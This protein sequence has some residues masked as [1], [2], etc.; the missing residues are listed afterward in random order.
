[1]EEKEEEEEEEEV[2]GRDRVEQK[3]EGKEEA[4]KNFFPRVGN[5]KRDA[6]MR[7]EGRERENEIRTGTKVA[8]SKREEEEEEQAKNG[9]IRIHA[10]CRRGRTWS[11][12]SRP[13]KAY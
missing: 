8:S 13:R 5:K 2:P 3:G 6:S 7:G 4:G 9:G 12:S 11:L 1:M 10:Y